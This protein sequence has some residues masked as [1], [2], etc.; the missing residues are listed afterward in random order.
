MEAPMVR[1]LHRFGPAPFDPLLIALMFHLF[2]GRS[3]RHDR[4]LDLTA[5]LTLLTLVR[6]AAL[7]W[8]ERGRRARICSTRSPT[9]FCS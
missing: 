4:V 2:D 5:V 8:T 1:S 3:G 9:P 6:H 7:L